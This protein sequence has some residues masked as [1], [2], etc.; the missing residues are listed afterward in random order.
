MKAYVDATTQGGAQMGSK[1][2]MNM[3]ARSSGA[4][5]IH[6]PIYASSADDLGKDL[7]QNALAE[8]LSG[9]QVT[10]EAAYILSTGGSVRPPIPRLPS[11]SADNLFDRVKGPGGGSSLATPRTIVFRNVLHS[12]SQTWLNPLGPFKLPNSP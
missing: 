4:N 2:A 1:A 9:K 10:D 12:Q 11:T 6:H 8:A 5:A 3:M 7:A